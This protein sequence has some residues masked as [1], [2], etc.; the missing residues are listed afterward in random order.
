[1]IRLTPMDKVIFCAG[2]LFVV[3][4]LMGCST[5]RKQWTEKSLYDTFVEQGI[6][7]E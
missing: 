3:L 1:M 7:K 4:A 2:V 6:I 5:P